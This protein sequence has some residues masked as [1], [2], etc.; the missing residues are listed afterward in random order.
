MRIKTTKNVENEL[1]YLKSRLD[2][3]NNAQVLKLA[4]SYAIYKNVKDISTVL[5]DG[6]AV[7]MGVIF[8]EQLDVYKY[9]LTEKY[10]GKE[11]REIIC[12]LIDYGIH[13]VLID[14][15]YAKNNSA[16]LVKN[17]VEDYVLG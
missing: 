15:R 4:V 5:E 14:L 6:F 7:D 13:E 9:L 10:H 11:F 3:D 12:F 8:G 2:F 1:D 17:V 16:T